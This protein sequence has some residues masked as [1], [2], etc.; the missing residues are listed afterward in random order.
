MPK[1]QKALKQKGR[2]CLGGGNGSLILQ[3][4]HFIIPDRTGIGHCAAVV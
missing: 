4:R 3:R 2:G 1:P